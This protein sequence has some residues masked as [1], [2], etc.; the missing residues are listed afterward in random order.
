[1]HPRVS[2]WP[3]EQSRLS[4]CAGGSPASPSAVLSRGYP[5]STLLAGG[6]ES[7]APVHQTSAA[8]LERNRLAGGPLLGF[9]TTPDKTRGARL[10]GLQRPAKTLE[11]AV[12]LEYLGPRIRRSGLHLASNL[13]VIPRARAVSSA[14]RCSGKFCR[15]VTTAEGLSD[16][17]RGQVWFLPEKL[18]EFL[19]AL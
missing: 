19:P 18:P 11:L 5:L 10:A 1:M 17:R 14:S 4:L 12:L 7:T 9:R 6:A 13:C 8:A 16:R 15:W 3:A 2:R